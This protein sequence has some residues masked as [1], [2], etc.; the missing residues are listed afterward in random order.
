MLVRFDF[1]VKNFVLLY[2]CLHINIYTHAHTYLC[3]FACD[4][5]FKE[6]PLLVKFGS[7]KE[8]IT[9]VT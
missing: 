2:L 4:L 1:S 5:A 7:K 3:L 6:R 9:I 8:Y